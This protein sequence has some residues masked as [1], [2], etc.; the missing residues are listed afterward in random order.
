MIS[1]VSK[2]ANNIVNSIK[3]P[4]QDDNVRCFKDAKCMKNLMD[5]FLSIRCIKNYR[6]NFNPLFLALALLCCLFHKLTLKN[7]DALSFSEVQ[8]AWVCLLLHCP[9][10]SYREMG[11]L[12][13]GS[14]FQSFSWVLGWQQKP[15]VPWSFFVLWLL[16]CSSH[17]N[18]FCK[19]VFHVW[20]A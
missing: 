8:V 2:V 5:I 18:V 11:K 9:G 10:P 13:R 16:L 4:Y 1:H 15:S 7:G 6:N 14:I 19:H 3:P 20:I 12:G 17:V